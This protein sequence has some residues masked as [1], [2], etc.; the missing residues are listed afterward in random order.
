M[1]VARKIL[2]SEVTQNPKRHMSMLASKSLTSR[3]QSIE[4]RTLKES[5]G[6]VGMEG[7]P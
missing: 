3:L 6:L 7:I 4:P 1:D 5:K 2:L